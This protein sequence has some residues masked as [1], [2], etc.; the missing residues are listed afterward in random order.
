MAN[1]LRY[2]G[3]MGSLT[4]ARALKRQTARPLSTDEIADIAGSGRSRGLFESFLNWLDMPAS[5]VRNV[6]G[7]TFGGPGSKGTIKGA[8]RSLGAFSLPGVVSQPKHG[9]TPDFGFWGNL[10]ADPLM[11]VTGGGAGAGKAVVKAGM[12]RLARHG[13]RRVAA[14]AVGANLT[15]RG[16][17][18]VD[19]SVQRL[20][21]KQARQRGAGHVGATLRGSTKE[22]RARQ[23]VQQRMAER[24]ARHFNRA[25]HLFKQG[26]FQYGVPFFGSKTFAKRGKAATIFEATLPYQAA[27]AAWT[28][29][30]AGKR[31]LPKGIRETF[32]G[33][34]LSHV[35]KKARKA[36]QLLPYAKEQHRALAHVRNA[37]VSMIRQGMEKDLG[38]IFHGWDDA[39]RRDFTQAIGGVDVHKSGVVNRASFLKRHPDLNYDEALGRWKNLQ[40]K[41]HGAE[42][43]VGA[44]GA[45]TTEEF[46]A[47]RMKKRNPLEAQ[48]LKA[49]NAEEA[50]ALEAALFK[51]GPLGTKLSRTSAQAALRVL[52][53]GKREH[54][55]L[56]KQWDE[57]VADYKKAHGVERKRPID[58]TMTW[59]EASAI[60]DEIP[61]E[62]R[63]LLQEG[64]HKILG[65]E[66]FI[67]LDPAAKSARLPPP[68]LFAALKQAGVTA[69][70]G[71]DLVAPTMAA[72]W[73]DDMLRR[74]A[75]AGEGLEGKEAAEAIQMAVDEARAGL[76]ARFNKLSPEDLARLDEGA[77]GLYRSPDVYFPQQ[78]TD[79]VLET[80][81]RANIEREA[82][83]LP[84]EFGGLAPSP[85][86]QVV[87]GT[88]EFAKGR[89]LEDM[90]SFLEDLEAKLAKAAEAGAPIHP[91]ALPEMDILELGRKRIG[92][93]AQ[94]VANA[95]LRRAANL[96]SGTKRGYRYALERG[97]GLDVRGIANADYAFGEWLA[98]GG[99]KLAPRTGF[100]KI[101]ADYNRKFFKPYVT[102][103]LGV[104]PNPA[105]VFRNM[106]SGIWQAVA[107]PRVGFASGMKHVKDI[108][109]EAVFQ[110]SEA[111]KRVW[112]RAVEKTPG[113]IG[114]H[115]GRGQLNRVLAGQGTEDL[116]KGLEKY[117]VTERIL[118]RELRRQ[119]ALHDF[120]HAEELARK[121]LD[122]V[123]AKTTRKKALRMLRK[124][125]LDT[126][127][128]AA[129]TQGVEARM[130]ANGFVA[131]L[132]KGLN[133]DQ[134][135]QAV[136]E[137][138][139][140]YTVVSDAHQAIRTIIPFAQ[141]TIGQ[142]PRTLKAFGERPRVTSIFRAAGL[143]G[144]TEP[145][146]QFVSEQPNIP[147]G[148][149]VEGNQARLVGL[150]TP[151]EDLN[152]LYAGG[153]ARTLQRLGA[154][155]TP[156]L[157][158]PLEVMSGKDLF[159]GTK[160]G[161]Y[162]RD[163]PVARPFPDFIAG[164]AKR[165]VTD[166]KTGEKKEITEVSPAF[167]K[168]L[169]YLPISRQLS[170]M[171]TLFDER[172]TVWQKSISLLTGA[173][174]VSV[175]QE[176]ELRRLIGDYLQDR[177][178]TT[179]DI[180]EFQRFFARGDID[181]E[182]AAMVKAYYNEQRTRRPRVG[183]NPFRMTGAGRR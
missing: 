7:A 44:Q 77:K 36:L 178:Q 172:R 102:I 87:K 156:P 8:L 158:L 63:R 73:E 76:A 119:G 169:Q 89:R 91:S 181:E 123:P 160:L 78:Y 69:P 130:R 32:L 133:F 30:V 34:K 182:L 86:G 159:F 71:S 167:L 115:L 120:V 110:T 174:V 162:R 161:H 70:K 1:A 13:A 12:G 141:F 53:L 37:E 128:P 40:T 16:Q 155:T 81:E 154:Q 26:G 165:T 9:E 82:A 112:G 99:G 10:A 101:F 183:K 24:F 125:F 84:P 20:L 45:A 18:F 42:K 4:G 179:G 168:A 171:N 58:A 136:R 23:I 150:G 60:A 129:I 116:V 61:D 31:V 59:D 113:G 121:A 137:T 46:V 157:K 135:G 93:H 139:I 83:N 111:I 38:K 124:A 166:V 33:A 144:G 106:V 74:A 17:K 145:L 54:K 170:Q 51:L 35:G 67:K 152:R 11:Y 80:F 39:A 25:P 15:R 147:L 104:F 88:S 19:R 22:L 62:A 28:G 90:P 164:R 49:K 142:A 57:I 131:A 92:A 105:F 50:G 132:K 180:G 65:W 75:Q 95:N 2:F 68:A 138:F 143:G 27:K 79:E 122:N 118:Y 5:A 103:G 127:I 114:R 175:N 47:R 109:E 85:R 41:I 66:E 117:G 96:A 94:S 98:K 108:G 56:V 72:K 29:K 126:D 134:A 21:R 148:R 151:F 146:P 177:V 64:E 163:V 173:K 97:R 52:N 3:G 6:L 140:D 149:D 153:A 48:I 14:G 100:I 43:R 55:A 107:D 176:R